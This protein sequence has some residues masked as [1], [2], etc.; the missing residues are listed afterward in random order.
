MQQMMNLNL[1]LKGNIA[2]KNHN[3]N[4]EN[5]SIYFLM[6]FSAKEP[7]DIDRNPCPV[8]VVT[9]TFKSE[10]TQT[11]ES[12]EDKIDH[13]NAPFISTTYEEKATQTPEI[14]CFKFE[15][16]SVI[17]WG[18]IGFDVFVNFV[19]QAVDE[20]TDLYNGIRYIL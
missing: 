2:F 9:V 4:H 20:G 8:D 12:V 16:G 11:S 19:L 17:A 1:N 18:K 7:S 14:L 3:L 13:E 5:I 15:K 10:A 6:V